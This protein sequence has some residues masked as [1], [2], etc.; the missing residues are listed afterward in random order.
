MQEPIKATVTEHGGLHRT[1][2]QGEACAAAHGVPNSGVGDG[3]V[4]GRG[5]IPLA[6]MSIGQFE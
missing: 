1:Q 6:C 5:R 4:L 2:R 3:G